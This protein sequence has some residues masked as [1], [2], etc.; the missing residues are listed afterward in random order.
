MAEAKDLARTIKEVRP[1]LP[2]KDFEKSR[3]FY[4]DLGFEERVL[5]DGLVEM[6]LGTCCFVLQ[7]YYVEDW[8]N[9]FVLH[10]RVSDVQSWWEHI[11][12]RDLAGRYGVKTRVPQQE[13][14]GLVLGFV[15][16]SG[17]L[18]RVAESAGPSLR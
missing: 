4:A 18:W 5:T 14:W 1:V 9:N 11:Q 6:R 8:A 3:R 15:D 7:N 17:V 10:V 13:A 16:P 12:Q 2:A